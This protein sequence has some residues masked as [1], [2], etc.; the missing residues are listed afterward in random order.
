LIGL[1]G[2]I[3]AELADELGEHVPTPV[4]DLARF[5]RDRKDQLASRPD[6]LDSA[7]QAFDYFAD[8]FVTVMCAD[9]RPSGPWVEAQV[10]WLHEWREHNEFQVVGGGKVMNAL[11]IGHSLLADSALR[12]G[13]KLSD[14]A[15][16]AERAEC[17]NK[18]VT[19]CLRATL[20]AGRLYKP[21][22]N[23]V[24]KG[25]Q[26]DVSLL[27]PFELDQ[28]FSNKSIDIEDHAEFIAFGRNAAS[29][30]RQ[31]AACNLRRT[32]HAD[33]VV[34]MTRVAAGVFPIS[35]EFICKVAEQL[36]A[37]ADA[38]DPANGLSDEPNFS[39]MGFEAYLLDDAGRGLVNAF[40][41]KIGHPAE[42]SWAAWNLETR[43]S[44]E[45]FERGTARG[46]A[47]VPTGYGQLTCALRTARSCDPDPTLDHAQLVPP[48][49]FQRAAK[50]RSRQRA[51]EARQALL[52]NIEKDVDRLKKCVSV[53]DHGVGRINLQT[54]S[55]E[56]EAQFV[57]DLSPLAFQALALLAKENGA[58]EVRLTL[59]RFPE[60]IGGQAGEHPSVRVINTALQGIPDLKGV[61]I[62][63]GFPVG[64]TVTADITGIRKPVPVTLRFK[65]G[66]GVRKVTVLANDGVD[67]QGEAS[68][69]I[70]RLATMHVQRPAKGGGQPTPEPLRFAQ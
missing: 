29:P 21:L 33:L 38:I 15:K 31:R 53:D 14:P 36:V 56:G 68:E 24:T 49:T 34:S 47:A 30:E 52:P 48:S 50:I 54:W 66:E 11:A 63:A 6:L 5:A 22:W 23:V 18:Y 27:S 70:Q 12:A 16:R 60:G 28:L 43:R 26:V 67:V 69:R 61:S 39:A 9:S 25:A 35:D 1:P 2:F 42:D 13:L 62:S 46:G 51:H 19:H 59:P 4:E 40:A 65:D 32:L 64:Q 3:T 45:K 58:R 55:S 7:R 8:A 37:R 57:K 44:E 17:F 41:Q 20:A 10:K